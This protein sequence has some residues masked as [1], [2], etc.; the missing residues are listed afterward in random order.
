LLV[1]PSGKPNEKKIH[2]LPRQPSGAKSD[3]GGNRLANE[4]QNLLKTGEV[5]KRR[6]KMEEKMEN[7]KAN[8]SEESEIDND[9]FDDVQIADEHSKIPSQFSVERSMEKSRKLQ[10]G[11]ERKDNEKLKEKENKYRVIEKEDRHYYHNGNNFQRN[12]NGGHNEYNHYNNRGSY[13]NHYD[14]YS[15]PY[16]TDNKYDFGGVLGMFFG[17]SLGGFFGGDD[18][19]GPGD[20]ASGVHQILESQPHYYLEENTIRPQRVQH[21]GRYDE[22]NNYYQRDIEEARRIREEEEAKLR[23]EQMLKKQMNQLRNDFDNTD[24]SKLGMFDRNPNHVTT[25]GH[26][27]LNGGGNGKYDRERDL[28]GNSQTEDLISVENQRPIS[29][30]DNGKPK[31]PPK[32]GQ[33]KNQPKDNGNLPVIE[34]TD[35]RELAPHV[36]GI[37]RAYLLEM[38][39]HAFLLQQEREKQERQKNQGVQPQEMEQP[40]A[41]ADAYLKSVFWRNPTKEE[42]DRG[43]NVGASSASPGE[44]PS[45]P[46]GPSAYE[47]KSKSVKSDGVIGNSAVKQEDPQNSAAKN[48]DA[49]KISSESSRQK[50]SPDNNEMISSNEKLSL[51]DEKAS[52]DNEMD[53][54]HTDEDPRFHVVATNDLS[55]ADFLHVESTLTE[56]AFRGD[57]TFGMPYFISYFQGWKMFL[58]S[59]KSKVEPHG[60][61]PR[62]VYYVL[63]GLLEGIDG[64]EVG[65]SRERLGSGS[66]VIAKVVSAEKRTDSSNSAWDGVQG[67]RTGE[68]NVFAKLGGLVE[69]LKID[70]LPEADAG[71]DEFRESQEDKSVEGTISL[72]L[73][74]VEGWGKASSN[75][76]VVHGGNNSS[77]I[78]NGTAQKKICFQE[79]LQ[80]LKETSRDSCTSEEENE[81]KET[82]IRSSNK[83]PK[84]KN[85]AKQIK[86]AVLEALVAAAGADVV[87]REWV[88]PYADEDQNAVNH[89]NTLGPL[90]PVQR[91]RRMF[92]V[93]LTKERV[94]EGTGG[95]E[96]GEVMF[97][98]G[99]SKS[100]SD[101][102]V[103]DFILNWFRKQTD[104]ARGEVEGEEGIY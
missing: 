43:A 3:R 84:H 46:L 77:G 2:E 80:N 10:K 21:V 11:E 101:Y 32:D 4:L 33:N 82:Q 6:E 39:K 44:R 66:R 49:K 83:N 19:D 71:I 7:R 63:E 15:D 28:R 55:R 90:T 61:V 23:E 40:Q 96:M 57:S 70:G 13:N 92:S 85:V 78:N 76:R 88:D 79:L 8:D 58:K 37:Q 51:K 56:K 89:N 50:R 34:R 26:M 52:S 95:E 91:V 31:S 53:Y 1:P 17:G 14:S 73:K 54:N 72:D 62:L 18:D 47:R 68:G 42:L 59:L 25:S 102:V 81:G 48:S 12:F 16:N 100:G 38:E 65:S 99:K 86:V 35:I 93:L 75:D 98:E 27:V 20:F 74:K 104:L 97:G 5:E 24:L 94:I 9:I 87:G 30:D 29:L 67:E 69:Y 45:L 36:E 64:T 22:N 60:P 103:Q 41:P